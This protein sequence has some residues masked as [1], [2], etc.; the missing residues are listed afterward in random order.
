MFTR[1]KDEHDK[2]GPYTQTQK[3]ILKK[4]VACEMT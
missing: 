2:K 1:K 4:I 3:E